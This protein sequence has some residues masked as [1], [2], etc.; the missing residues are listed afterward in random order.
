MTWGNQNTEAEAH[1]QLSYAFDAGLNFLDTAGGY[2]P[3]HAQS[4]A[5]GYLLT[6][7]AVA[8]PRHSNQCLYFLL[9]GLY[10]SL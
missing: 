9:A 10:C 3:D 2:W 7:E 6:K 8:E 5:V 4:L 1:E